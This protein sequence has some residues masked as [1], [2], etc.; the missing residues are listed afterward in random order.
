MTNK[1]TEKEIV[2]E[3]AS[4]Q[5]TYALGELLGRQAKPGQ[6]YCLDGDLG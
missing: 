4:F 5:E 1:K 2:R 3:T 6:I